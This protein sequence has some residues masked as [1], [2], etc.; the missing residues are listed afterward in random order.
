MV[1]Y[2]TLM[3]FILNYILG[4]GTFVGEDETVTLHD[5]IVNFFT[6][7]A[8]T[9]GRM[10]WTP[11]ISPL[12]DLSNYYYVIAHILTILA[13]ISLCVMLWKLLTLPIK[14]ALNAVK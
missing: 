7:S 5:L 4:F 1:L 2:D 8:G 14:W 13:C 12:G 10:V 9:D 11:F 3:A 6:Y